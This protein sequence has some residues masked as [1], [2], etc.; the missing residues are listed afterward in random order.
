M[1][2][3]LNQLSRLFKTPSENCL[4]RILFGRVPGCDEG[5]NGDDPSSFTR[6]NIGVLCIQGLGRC[7]KLRTAEQRFKIEPFP[8]DRV[9]TRVEALF[10]S[11]HAI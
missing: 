9:T 6:G 7:F 3:F 1:T 11:S 8:F 4:I 5:H 10:N 2:L